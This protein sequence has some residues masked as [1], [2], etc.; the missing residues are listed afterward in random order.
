MREHTDPP[1][2]DLMDRRAF[3]GLTGRRAAAVVGAFAAGLLVDTIWARLVRGWHL[4]REEYP[5]LVFGR[6]R[7]HH[8][9]VGYVLLLAGLRFHPWVL[10]PAGLG[11]IVG[12]RIRD[13]L[14]WFVERV[15]TVETS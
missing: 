4:E 13:R 7:V 14:F 12:H 8:N 5:K 9:V 10:V 1:P 6:Y 2:T 11:M 3:L 15:E